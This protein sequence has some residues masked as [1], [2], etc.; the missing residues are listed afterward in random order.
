MLRRTRDVEVTQAIYVNILNKVQ[1]LEVARA[2]TIGNIRIIDSAVLNG[3]VAPNVLRIFLLYTVLGLL[4]V[5]GY[6]VLKEL[7][8]RGVESS[9][10]I[11][12]AGLTVYATVPQS[13]SQRKLN[14][15]LKR[16]G[17]RRPKVWWE[18]CWPSEIR[19]I[20][21]SSRYEAYALAFTLP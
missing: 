15:E 7:L 20:S 1:E 11:E 21:L 3:Q 5:I 16:R 6:V 2:G 18:A 17:K 9:E 4:L 8:K 10:Q 14:R 19:W 12:G 13:S